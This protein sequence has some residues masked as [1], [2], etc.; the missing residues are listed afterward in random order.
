MDYSKVKVIR[1]ELKHEETEEQRQRREEV[2][3]GKIADRRQREN[4]RLGF[5]LR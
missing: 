4:V 5:Y 2:R 1:R 3:Q